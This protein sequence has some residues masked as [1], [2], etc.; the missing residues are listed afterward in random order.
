MKLRTTCF[1]LAFAALLAGMLAAQG[2]RDPR[3][4]VTVEK[5]NST[6]RWAILVGVNDYVHI[7]NLKYCV[8][9]VSTLR[10][11]LLKHGYDDKRMFCL[12][13]RSEA[14]PSFQPTRANIGRVINQVFRQMQKG[15]QILIV[16]SGHGLMINEKS[17]FCPEDADPNNP[18][19][20]LINIEQLY[21]MLDK[22]NATNKMLVVDA[23]RNR[24]ADST[25]EVPEEIIAETSQDPLEGVRSVRGAKGIEKLPEPPRGI[26]LLS[27]CDE[28]EYSFED[29]NLEHGVFT[30]FLIE[31]IRGKA[32]TNGDGLISL[33]ELTSYVCE[34]TPL[35]TM[36]K[37]SA[38]QTP[39]LTG[40][41]TAYY[42][43]TAEAKPNPPSQATVTP[44][45]GTTQQEPSQPAQSRGTVKDYKLDLTKVALG[46]MPPGWNGPGNAMV[47]NVGGSKCVTSNAD[48]T[49]EL[50]L[51]D[52]FKQ[53]G[54][55][56]LNFTY[57]VRISTYVDKAAGKIMDE[58]R[59]AISFQ[60]SRSNVTFGDSPAKTYQTGSGNIY[61][62]TYTITRKGSILSM[63]CEGLGG[64]V[65]T[66][67]SDTFKSLT[68]FSITIP[69]THAGISH[70]TVRSPGGMDTLPVK[71]YTLNL[72]STALGNPPPTGWHG[73]D[74]A[75]VNNVG[76]SKCV[77]S[78]SDRNI[79]ELA[80]A[81][82]F[83]QPGDFVLN[84]TCIT[85]ISTYVD[86]ASGKIMDENGNAI[87]FQVSRSHVS[88]G[89]SPVKTYQSG[90]GNTYSNTYTI[91]RKGNILNM[92]CEGLEGDTIVHR[93]DTFKSLTGFTITIPSTNVGISQFSVKSLD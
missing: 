63:T 30:H 62:N 12:T 5:E 40:K 64:E 93:S 17:Y 31:G 76:G 91:T 15:D 19:A 29:K 39:Y 41:T 57:V 59:N 73:L 4:F 53:P 67:R 69:S 35:H 50:V 52:I 6:R 14:G 13:T 78:S 8:N 81:D 77:T 90:G 1:T 23:C 38:A 88:F 51:S 26:A 42:V 85:R 44:P 34:E 56:V 80:I 43:A 72:S 2:Q 32:D 92:T 33:L 27:S 47:G 21:D 83:S 86:D 84:F 87:S 22:S 20:T 48:K 54:D 74:N 10:D 24:P 58:N 68:G 9:D 45:N 36:K 60:V 75:V 65:I 16:L 3:A 18:E 25:E 70:F 37:F 61:S 11:E 82:L 46:D 79:V 7:G 89:S 55:F 49:T 66:T 71:D 28:G